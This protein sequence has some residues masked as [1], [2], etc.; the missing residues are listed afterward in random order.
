MRKRKCG[1]TEMGHLHVRMVNILV[2]TKLENCH[3][4]TTTPLIVKSIIKIV[5]RTLTETPLD[6]NKALP[7]DP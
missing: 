2:L 7:F 5:C 6:V 3:T 4:L 1:V